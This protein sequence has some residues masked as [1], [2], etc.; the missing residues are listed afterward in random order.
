MLNEVHNPLASDSHPPFL[1]PIRLPTQPTTRI[2]PTQVPDVTLKKF[3]SELAG[4]CQDVSGMMKYL[5]YGARTS[6]RS[7]GQRKR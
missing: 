1:H 6:T 3:Y 5:L 7:V 4:L 2:D